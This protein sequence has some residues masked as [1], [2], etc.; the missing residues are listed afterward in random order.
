MSDLVGNPN[1]W[2]CHA[3]AHF[4]LFFVKKPERVVPIA[5]LYA[6]KFI[7]KYMDMSPG[8][9]ISVKEKSELSAHCGH[10]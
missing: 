2:F 9:I 6:R 5:S 7:P 4:K 3:Q 10:P 8:N 1:C